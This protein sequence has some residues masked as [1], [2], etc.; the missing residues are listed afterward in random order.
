[1]R[2]SSA[3]YRCRKK[4]P[5]SV[6]R[7]NV[8]LSCLRYIIYQHETTMSYNIYYYDTKLQTKNSP[9]VIPTTDILS[10]VTSDTQIREAT[11]WLGRCKT[12]KLTL[13]FSRHLLRRWKIRRSWSLLRRKRQIYKVNARCHFSFLS[14]V[15]WAILGKLPTTV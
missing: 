3:A 12:W 1:M 15:Y 6:K 4:N 5:P 11:L 7:K 14:S 2:L 8:L 9:R 13:R 10:C